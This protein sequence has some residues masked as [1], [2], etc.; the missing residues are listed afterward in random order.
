MTKAEQKKKI[1]DAAFD[2]FMK[3]GIKAVKMDDIATMMGMSKRTLYEIF[4]TKEALLREVI[5]KSFQK[6]DKNLQ[7]IVESA[8]GD[9]LKIL[10][11]IFHAQVKMIASVNPVFYDD[12]MSYPDLVGE[13]DKKRKSSRQNIDDFFAQGVRSGIFRKEVNYDIL[14]EIFMNSASA[15][16]EKKM[17]LKYPMIDFYESFTLV[18]FRGVMTDEALARLHQ[19]FKI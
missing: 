1:V 2:C 3:N 11:S 18:I 6:R 16:V 17:L 7:K 19:D 5:E 15:I 4:G 9:I 12:L 8:N 13:I 10:V 14:S